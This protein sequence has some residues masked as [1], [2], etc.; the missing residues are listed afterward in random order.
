MDVWKIS[1]AVSIN[2]I[3]KWDLGLKS[4]KKTNSLVTIESSGDLFNWP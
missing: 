4:T 1:S 3:L 2:V